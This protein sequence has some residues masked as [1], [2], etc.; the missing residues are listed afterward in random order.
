MKNTV[1]KMFH[2]TCF[3]GLVEAIKFIE[4]QGKTL[5]KQGKVAHLSYEYDPNCSGTMFVG[6]SKVKQCL[7][8]ETV[9]VTFMH[10]MVKEELRLSGVAFSMGV[11]KRFHGLCVQDIFTY[12]RQQR[13]VTSWNE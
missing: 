11:I 4:E 5:E 2:E 9:F 13:S 6:S 12:C 1:H 3:Q 7:S 8:T 10:Q